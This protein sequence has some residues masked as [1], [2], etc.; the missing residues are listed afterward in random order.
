MGRVWVFTTIKTV[1]VHLFSPVYLQ[2]RNKLARTN[3]N[4]DFCVYRCHDVFLFSGKPKR[5]TKK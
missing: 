2:Q 1:R 4:S 3:R 5:Q